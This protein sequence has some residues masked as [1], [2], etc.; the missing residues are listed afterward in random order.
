MFCVCWMCNPLLIRKFMHK[1][2][3]DL[4]HK[5]QR[6]IDSY[7]APPSGNV[8]ATT[9]KKLFYNKSKWI[10]LCQIHQFHEECVNPKIMIFEYRSTCVLYVYVD[11]W[12]SKPDTRYTKQTNLSGV[13]QYKI[14][15]NLRVLIRY[16]SA[17]GAR[18]EL[19]KMT[20]CILS[21]LAANTGWWDN[22]QKYFVL[23]CI[24]CYM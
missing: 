9:I 21:W 15:C 18:T 13:D 12:H 1:S 8:Y 20:V 14:M 22:T 3:Y 17:K 23:N 2:A 6:K 16:K 10:F 4:G 19:P 11:S 5:N 24:L 7:C